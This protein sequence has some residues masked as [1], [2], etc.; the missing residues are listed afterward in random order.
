MVYVTVKR[1]GNGEIVANGE[2]KP[3]PTSY[4][5]GRGAE[6]TEGEIYHALTYGKNM[7]GHYRAQLDSRERWIVT[8][9]VQSLQNQEK[10]E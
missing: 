4:L 10:G 8:H 2:Y 6:L 1:D 3:V 5:E 9:Y 7:M